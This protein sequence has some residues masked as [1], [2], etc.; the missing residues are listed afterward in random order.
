MFIEISQNS[1]E[2]NSAKASF[3]IKLQVWG[4][5]F[6]KK[7][8]LAQVFFCEFCEISKNTFSTDHLRTPASGSFRVFFYR[9]Y[10]KMCFQLRYKSCQVFQLS[11]ARHEMVALIR[12]LH[13]WTVQV[14]C[15]RC[16]W[17][18]LIEISKQSTK[19]TRPISFTCFLD[20][21]IIAVSEN[22]VG[23][24]VALKIS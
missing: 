1:Q 2:N 9:L 22:T 10:Y 16:K 23:G 7:E 3:L 15:S 19:T 18:I 11:R 14:H 21:F 24:V 17:I 4:C 8:T 12:N 20:G 5:N 6:I 13:F